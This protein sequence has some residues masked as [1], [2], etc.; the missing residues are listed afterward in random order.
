MRQAMQ[1]RARHLIL[2]LA[3]AL[4]LLG[5]LALGPS[6]CQGSRKRSCGQAYDHL[7]LIS[8]QRP[9]A[10]LRAQFIDACVEAF[11]VDRHGCLM[12]AQTPEAALECRPKRFHSE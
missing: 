9:D 6:G 10:K 3:L 11:D 4:P 1:R 5:A 8:K 12:A 7:A 2:A